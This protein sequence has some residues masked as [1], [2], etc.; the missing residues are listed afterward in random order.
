MERKKNTSNTKCY[1]TKS[2]V[3]LRKRIIK[4]VAYRR[5]TLSLTK[6]T[7][8]PDTR[9]ASVDTKEPPAPTK[10]NIDSTKT[11]SNCTL[12]VNCGNING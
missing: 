10:D 7:W 3:I 11:Y 2:S 8:K 12:A 1:A 4:D 6:Y 5:Y 9:V